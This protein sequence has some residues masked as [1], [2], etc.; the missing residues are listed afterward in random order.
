MKPFTVLGYSANDE[1]FCPACLRST[2]GLGPS[3]ADYNGRPILPLTHG[4]VPW[5][6]ALTDRGVLV[7][8][9]VMMLASFHSYFFY[10]WLPKYLTAT[11]GLGNVEA[12]ALAAGVLAGSAPAPPR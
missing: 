6:A 5:R 1:V 10:S 9:L 11:R 3:D 4:P 8:C 12:G 7:L 2:T